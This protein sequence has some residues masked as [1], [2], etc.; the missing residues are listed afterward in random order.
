MS[1]KLLNEHHL[2]FLSLEGGCTGSYE[3]THVEMPYCCKS[4]ALAHF[5]RSQANLN[6]KAKSNL[7]TGLYF[8]IAHWSGPPRTYMD[9]SQDRQGRLVL[10]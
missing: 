10:C 3:S 7:F 4:H 9:F 8:T 5:I 1:V 6:R 2:E